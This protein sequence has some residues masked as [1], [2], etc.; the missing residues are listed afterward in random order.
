MADFNRVRA[1]RLY[2][3]NPVTIDRLNPLYDVNDGDIVRV[4]NL[5]GCPEANTMGHA[6]LDGTFGGLVCTNSLRTEGA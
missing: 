4:V 3:Y 1:G 2:R 6:H 5:P